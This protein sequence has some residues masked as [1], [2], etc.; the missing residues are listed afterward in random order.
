MNM[1]TKRN[2]LDNEIYLRRAERRVQDIR[3]D[4]F[5]D[6][7]A[8]LHSS[9]FRRLKHKAQVFLAPTNDHVCTRIEHVLHVASIASTV[10]KGLGLDGDLAQAIALGHDLGH[11]PF[12]HS[13]ERVVNEELRDMGGFRHELHSLRVVDALSGDGRGLNLTYAVRDGIISHCGEK[14]E[15]I[16][17][18]HGGFKE[19]E[20]VTDLSTYP[21][22]Y[23]GCVVR[24][25]DKIAYLGRDVEDAV[26]AGI[27]ES[28]EEVPEAAR[29]V[30]GNT[31]GEV[32][33]SL[34]LDVIEFSKD[35]DGIGFSPEKHSAVL[36]FKEFNYE[37]IY[38]H[39]R[40]VE[41][42]RFCG[43]IIRRL[44][45]H[46]LDLYDSRGMA[47]ERYE[48]SN[49][50]MERKFGGYLRDMAAFYERT[51]ASPKRVVADYVAGMT[52]LFALECIRQLTIPPPFEM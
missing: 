6:Q 21:T 29:L 7:T 31:N 18:P 3:G 40:I 41:H 8:I 5:R 27:L 37:R 11:T 1:T 24:Q 12:G 20:A 13:G 38:K 44:F 33:N 35:Q 45:A 28:F 49:I 19:L 34:V 46:F 39:P 4:Y 22:T 15:Q 9:P 51:D 14:F 16:I 50:V 52:D 10:C 48:A 42:E 47:S 32:I 17:R 36:G 25:A 23:E 43:Q 30:L 26:I 2:P